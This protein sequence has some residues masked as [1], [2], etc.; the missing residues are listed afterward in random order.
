M[1]NRIK[2]IIKNILII[3]PTLFYKIKTDDLFKD[4]LWIKK[5]SRLYSISLKFIPNY[6]MQLFFEKYCR[7]VKN[8]IYTQ[9]YSVDDIVDAWFKD[10][11]KLDEDSKYILFNF[12]YFCEIMNDKIMKKMIEVANNIKQKKYRY[13][14]T[15]DMSK[16]TFRLQKGFYSDYYNDRRELLKKIAKENNLNIPQVINKKKK[17]KLC[18]IT[19]LLEPNIFNSVQRVTKMISRGLENYFDEILVISLDSFGVSNK[20]KRKI[21]TPFQ[22]HF[23]IKKRKKIIEMLGSDKI[24]I[25]FLKEQ[26][27]DK[28]MQEAI[29]VIYQYNPLAILDV[30]DEYSSISYYYSKDFPTFYIPLRNYASSS[31]FN[32]MLEKKWRYENH[33]DRFNSLDSNCVCDWSFPEYVPKCEKKYTR[34]EINI[35][36]DSFVIITIGNND[37]V[38]DKL[39]ADKICK[40]LLDND[41]FV[42]L[43][44]GNNAPEYMHMKYSEL[45]ENKKIIEWGFEKNLAG[46]CS[47]GDI[48]LRPNTTGSSG[49]TAIAAQQGLPVVMTSFN[50]DPMRW[51][52]N[53]YSKIDNYDGLVD[54]IIHLYEDKEY[55]SEKKNIILNK[56]NEATNEEKIWNKLNDIIKSKC[57]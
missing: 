48:T 43:L 33:N 32:Y 12:L 15:M 8:E 27:F 2:K 25:S 29:D 31:F 38:I 55:Y 42:W 28:R 40:M 7:S 11:D 4:I 1:K 5:L 23:A 19:Y 36:E 57:S 39:F 14:L 45:F 44:I 35:K 52:G 24:K 30:S 41:K 53:D 51:I 46:L 22:F 13:W 6:P 17:N 16:I 50:C 54:E 3:F 34:K 37:K 10:I 26:D 20:D 9:N 21:T 18:I 56:V 49:A 47:I